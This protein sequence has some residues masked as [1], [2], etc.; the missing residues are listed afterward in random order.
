MVGKSCILIEPTLR[1]ENSEGSKFSLISWVGS[2]PQQINHKKKLLD[3]IL[4]VHA[5]S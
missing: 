4:T 3:L 5:C 2:N 1:V